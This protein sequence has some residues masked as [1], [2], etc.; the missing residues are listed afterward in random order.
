MKH[1]TY[2]FFASNSIRSVGTCGYDQSWN[3]RY[4]RGSGTERGRCQALPPLRVHRVSVQASWGG[5]HEHDRQAYFQ[6]CMAKNGDVPT[7]TPPTKP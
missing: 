5:S 1:K 2:E 7:P 4:T 3:P 6:D